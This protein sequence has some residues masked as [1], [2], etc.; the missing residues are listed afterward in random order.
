MKNN[1]II[2]ILFSY[3]FLK[4]DSTF[5]LN[6]TVIQVDDYVK[7]VFNENNDTIYESRGNNNNRPIVKLFPY[8]IGEKLYFDMYDIGGEGYVSFIAYI[9]E[10]TIKPEHQKFW[11]C[12]NC[13]GKNRNYRYNSNNKRFYFYYTQDPIYRI[14]VIFRF[15]FQINS[16]SELN[17][18]G[19]GLQSNFYSF[20][21]EKNF[22]IHISNLEEEIDIINFN[23]TD[24]FYMTNNKSLKTPFNVMKFKIFFDELISF[25]GKFI[26]LDE[27]KNDIELKNH[28]L[29]EVSEKKG[30]RYKLSR[31]EKDKKGVYLKIKIQS[32]NSPSGERLPQILSQKGEFNFFIFFLVS[33]F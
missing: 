29:F 28:D 13:A 16:Y 22:F 4:I 15:Y 7:R 10:Y 9:N 23:T 18:E 8:E 6:I 12:I 5:Y 24:I 32:Y 17:F 11:T 33:K 27:S 19:N 1:I 30:L 26:G 21:E 31:T 25:S 3:L 2:L 14:N 20:T